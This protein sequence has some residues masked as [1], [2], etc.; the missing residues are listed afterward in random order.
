MRGNWREK[1]E[2]SKSTKNNNGNFYQKI[3]MGK[4]LNKKT[5]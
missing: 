2:R 4:H 1:K 3:K 5:K